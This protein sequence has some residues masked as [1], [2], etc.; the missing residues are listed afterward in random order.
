MATQAENERLTRIGPGTPMGNLLRRYWQPVGTEIEL[1]KEPV[2]R[3]RRLGEDLTLFRSERGE[4]GLIDDRCPHRCMSLEFGIPEECGLRCAYH[5]WLFDAKGNCLEMPFE[6][7]THPE[8]RYKEK[9][10]IKAYPCQSLGG[11]VFAY[12]GPAPAPLLP[13]W[14][15]LLRDDLDRVVE[16]HEL[17]CNWVQCMDNAADP[18]HFEFLHAG[19]GNYQLKKLGRPPAMNPA[20]HVKIAFDVFKY[21]II[22]RRLLDGEPETSDEWT[23]GH[24]LLFPNILAVG[25]H[26][27]PMLQYRVPIDDTHTIQFGYRTS[28]RKPGAEPRPIAVK[29]SQLFNGEGKIVADTVPSQDMTA[30]I[31]QGPISDRTREH[32]ATSDRG[33]ALYHRMLTEQ[34]DRVE[35]GEEPMAL[36]RDTAENEPMIN[37]GREQRGVAPAFHSAYDNYFEKIEESSDIKGN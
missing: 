18:V 27:A 29:H 2:Q 30:W 14:D 21:G 23:T 13:R 24:P 10:K 22:K 4:Y 16:I 1:A 35:R 11:L 34:A 12:F 25:G 20:R 8:L 5:G 31:G 3:V 9:I 28:A 17:A 37:L 32:L 6:D 26:D 15:V 19:F 7:L 36:V 33:V